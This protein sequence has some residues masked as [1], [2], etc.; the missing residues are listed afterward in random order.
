MKI[1]EKLANE[2]EEEL[3]DAEKYAMDAVFYK[4]ENPMLAK[5]YWD[6][7]NEEMRH[8]DMLH[9]EVVGLIEKHRREHGEPPAP[10]QAVYDF[11]HKRNIEWAAEI[12]NIQSQYRA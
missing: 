9:E 7:S 1:I 8:A 11:L 2:I 12:K 10:M 5:T 6:M 4:E 3:E